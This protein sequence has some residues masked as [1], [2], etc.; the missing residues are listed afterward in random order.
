MR[1]FGF[2][3]CRSAGLNSVLSDLAAHWPLTADNVD[4]VSSQLLSLGVG[5]SV[6]GTSGIFG[7]KNL[8]VPTT[9]TASLTS[10]RYN[11]QAAPFSISLFYKR[12]G[13][14]TGTNV[15]L[16]YALA[17]TRSFYMIDTGALVG[18]YGAAADANARLS[19][20]VAVP[21]DTWVHLGAI[22]DGAG[23]VDLFYNGALVATKTG[24]GAL[25]SQAGGLLFVGNTTGI[26]SPQTVNVNLL[27]IGARRW[28]KEHVAWLYNGGAGRKYP[29]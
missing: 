12:T 2:G 13:A 25:T 19:Y 26:T 6:G 23:N 5:S 3:D 27:T 24:F 14:S 18:F 8:I 10:N 21:S 11:F 20:A 4:V 1:G 7:T 29:F 16:G 17:G 15:A 28:S 22:A 9:K